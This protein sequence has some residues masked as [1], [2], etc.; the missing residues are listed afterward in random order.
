VAYTYVRELDI[1]TA[2]LVAILRDGDV[3]IPGA[4]RRF[5]PAT[6]SS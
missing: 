2:T 6:K 5:F 1:A 3:L 4:T